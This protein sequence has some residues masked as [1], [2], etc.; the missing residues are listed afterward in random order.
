MCFTKVEKI[1]YGSNVPSFTD[2]RRYKPLGK[3]MRELLCS[4]GLHVA[5]TYIKRK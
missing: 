3:Y 5:N 1:F 2:Q 4:R